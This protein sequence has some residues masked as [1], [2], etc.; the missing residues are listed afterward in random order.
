VAPTDGA[1]VLADS[2]S[3]EGECSTAL[4]IMCV[5]DATWTNTGWATTAAMRA[6]AV[7]PTDGAR[8]LADSKSDEGECSTALIIMCVIDATPLSK[9]PT[10]IQAEAADPKLYEGER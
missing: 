9:E 7:A 3:D 8:V 2:K 1:R 4:I 10:Q 5:V 6:N